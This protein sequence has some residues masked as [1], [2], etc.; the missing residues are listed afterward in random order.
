MHRLARVSICL[1]GASL[2]GSMSAMSAM[3]MSRA[4]EVAGVDH[5]WLFTAA[6]LYML[7]GLMLGASGTAMIFMLTRTR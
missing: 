1:T 2:G 7:S 5:A 6:V 4:Y 3:M